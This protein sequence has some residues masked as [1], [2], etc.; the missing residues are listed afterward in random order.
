MG[1]NVEAVQQSCCTEQEPNE[2]SIEEL[3]AKAILLGI[4]YHQLNVRNHNNGFCWYLSGRMA[5]PTKNG[6][7]GRATE[8]ELIIDAMKALYGVDV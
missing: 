2:I 1:D 3:R 6:W 8:R 7:I 4:G 5:L